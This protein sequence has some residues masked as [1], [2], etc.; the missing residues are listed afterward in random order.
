VK[1]IELIFFNP[2]ILFNFLINKKNLYFLW[3]RFFIYLQLRYW[4]FF[5]KKYYKLFI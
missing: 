4:Y 5:I 2:P 1:N 3:Y